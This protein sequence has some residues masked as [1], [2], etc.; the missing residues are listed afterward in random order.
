MRL[1]LDE[2]LGARG[3][4]I[5]RAA[6]HDVAT[7]PA[8]GLG[9]A[10]DVKVIDV[11]RDEDRCLVTSDIDFANPLV[12]R[13]RQYRGIA[14]LRLPPNPSHAHLLAAVQTLAAHLLSDNIMQRLWF[15]EIGRVRIYQ[16][17]ASEV[18]ET[19]KGSDEA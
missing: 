7:V 10:A 19:A 17:D 15:V 5:L 14:V 4:E 11:C 18:V 13:P 9:S 12:Y 2:N 3:A 1:K 6:G 16:D 8:Q